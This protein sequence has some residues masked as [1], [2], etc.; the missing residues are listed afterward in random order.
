MAFGGSRRSRQ[1]VSRR[2]SHAAGISG[3]LSGAE[4]STFRVQKNSQLED[5]SLS[6]GTIRSKSGATVLV[7]N[8]TG[9]TDSNLALLR[10]FSRFRNCN[11]IALKL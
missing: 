1:V 7:I 5:K 11:D 2:R 3:Y 8:L 4:I 6:E 9:Q 10:F